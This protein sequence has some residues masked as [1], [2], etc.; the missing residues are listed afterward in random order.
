MAIV[1][2]CRRLIAGSGFFPRSSG[3]TL[4][5]V[6]QLVVLG[7]VLLLALSAPLIYG[8]AS[9]GMGRPPRASRTSFRCLL[10]SGRAVFLD[11]LVSLMVRMGLESLRSGSSA[12]SLVLFTVTLLSSI[13]LVLLLFSCL[14][15]WLLDWVFP[16]LRGGLLLLLLVVDLVMALTMAL[17]TLLTSCLT[18]RVRLRRL[19]LSSWPSSRVLSSAVV[20]LVVLFGVCFC[21]LSLFVSLS[22]LSLIHI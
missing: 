22:L 15:V 19:L 14:M 6:M 21:S 5:S 17:S 2:L 10:G 8:F 16:L 4:C 11:P 7:V 20:C 1:A 13:M 12:V 3:G 18:L 9:G